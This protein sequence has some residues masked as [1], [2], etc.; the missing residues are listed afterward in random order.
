MIEWRRGR[1]GD[2]SILRAVEEK[3][4]IALPADYRRLI[5]AQSG[6]TPLP[7]IFTLRGRERVF[8]RLLSAEAAKHPNLADA[9]EWTTDFD[10]RLVPFAVDPFGNLLCF[11]YS[12]DTACTVVFADL[13]SGEVNPVSMSFTGLLCLLK[14]R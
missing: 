8:D 2:E 13:E 10:R 9:L 4:G 1:P 11:S 12:T 7:R 6:A 14:E 3:M 5:L